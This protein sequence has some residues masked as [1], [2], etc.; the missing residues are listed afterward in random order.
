MAQVK[1]TSLIEEARSRLEADVYAD[2][3]L[4]VTLVEEEIAATRVEIDE[5]RE[6]VKALEKGSEVSA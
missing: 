6:R 2:V 5:L 1:I 4:A 3:E